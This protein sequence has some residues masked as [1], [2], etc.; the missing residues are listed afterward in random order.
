MPNE[1]LLELSSGILSS[2][3][4]SSDEGLVLA[5]NPGHIVQISGSLTHSLVGLV[6]CA[7]SAALSKTKYKCINRKQVLGFIYVKSTFSLLHYTDMLVC[8][9]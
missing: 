7:I 5:T 4:C 8:L 1:L 6:H 3:S 2:L 9:V